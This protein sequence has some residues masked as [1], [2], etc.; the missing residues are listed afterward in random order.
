M[1]L[2]FEGMCFLSHVKGVICKNEKSQLTFRPILCFPVCVLQ[3]PAPAADGNPA[4]EQSDGAVVPDALPHAA[5]LPV[6]PRV[7]RMVLQPADGDDRGQPGV[8]RGPGQEAP[9]GAEAVPAQEDQD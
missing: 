9:Q 3:P 5:R 4:A 2:Q 8:Q 7:Q 1:H 6:P